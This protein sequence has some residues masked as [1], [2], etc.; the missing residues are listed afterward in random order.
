MKT[1]LPTVLFLALTATP[2][3]ASG[4]C[5]MQSQIYNWTAP[6][7]RTLIVEDNWHKKFKLSLIGVCSHLK[8]HEQIGFRSPGSTGL[9]CLSRG[10]DVV[11]GSSIGP[12]T[13]AITDIEAYTPQMQHADDIAAKAQKDAAH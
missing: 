13:C 8:F 12:E 6:N 1:K 7:D 2:A 11:V 9:S 10:D 3:L 5:L 4:P